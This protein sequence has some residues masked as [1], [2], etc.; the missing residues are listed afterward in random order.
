MP[1]QAT[2][3]PALAG[4]TS[5]RFFAACYVLLFH[6]RGGVWF[7]AGSTGVTLFF[8]LSGFILAYNHPVVRE[9]ARKRFYVARFARIYP[10]YFFSFLVMIVPFAH[11]SAGLGHGP[12]YI[13]S[14]AA[15][16][17][18]LL[19]AWYPPFHWVVNAGS[20][21][22]V[23]E[24]MFYALFP[25][26]VVWMARFQ[27]RW[28]LTIAVLAVILVIP[29]VLVDFALVHQPVPLL[30]SL[31][32]LLTL[33]IFH[34]GE[35]LIGITLGLRFL[36]HRPVFTGWHVLAALVF[37][38]A[39]LAAAGLIIGVHPELI[40]NGAMAIPYGALIYSIAGWKSRILANPALQLGGEVSY[41]IYLLQGVFVEW[42]QAIFHHSRNF[43]ALRFAVLFVMAYSTYRLIEKPCRRWILNYFHVRSHPKPIETP[44]VALP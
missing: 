32:D 44:G 1:E 2:E 23:V 38:I 39:S 26:A 16:Y 27:R 11:E 28:M 17:L 30:V 15:M 43:I 29:A 5:L 31:Y 9:G 14:A 18:L 40:I 21:T 37:C 8:V 10:L 36:R 24:T 13:V 22:L 41:G 12:G 25:F 34:L 20:W 42:T 3:K 19:H 7:R 33:P 6:T 35:F 4:L